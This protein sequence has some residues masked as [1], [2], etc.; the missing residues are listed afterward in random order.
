MRAAHEEQAW[1][2]VVQPGEHGTWLTATAQGLVASMISEVVEVPDTREELQRLLGGN[3]IP[4]A[5]LRIG[6]GAP[7]VAS[8]RRDI[9]DML[10]NGAAEAFET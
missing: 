5:L 8:P 3:V 4:R 10:V 1:P 2:H 6:H 9:G 7:S